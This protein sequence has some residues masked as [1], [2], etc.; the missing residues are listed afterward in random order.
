MRRHILLK[1]SDTA[2]RVSSSRYLSSLS[3][4][5]SASNP[6]TSC[7]P[8]PTP[9]LP[10][11][12]GYGACVTFPVHWGDMDTFS[13]V[14]NVHY[15]R[16]LESGRIAALMDMAAQHVAGV[17]DAELQRALSSFMS[18]RGI[19]VILKTVNVKYKRPLAYP[20]I[21][22]V[23]SALTQLQS[24]RFTLSHVIVSARQQAVVAEGGGTLV[25]YDYDRRDKAPLPAIVHQAVAQW[26]KR[27]AGRVE[28]HSSLKHTHDTS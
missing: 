20:D 22:T 13:H 14:N 2:T 6:F 5:I 18:G 23:G 27:Y 12:S 24:D 10:L 11:L 4:S 15:V 26:G 19:G 8:P 9:L 17:P 7:G 28:E 1:A 25:C 16:Y 21:V 3:S